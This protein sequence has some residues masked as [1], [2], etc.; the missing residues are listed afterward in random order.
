LIEKEF[1]IKNKTGL[2]ARPATQFV[3]KAAS[4]K[5]TIKVRKG[6]VEVNAKSLISLLSLGA[7]MGTIITVTADGEDEND[8]V[9]G[10]VDLLESL[11]D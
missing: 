8:A 9:D 1:T 6:P 4:Y 5:C 11:N 3:K 10:L 2:H 7:N